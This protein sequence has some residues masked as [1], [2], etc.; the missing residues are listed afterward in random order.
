M[1][2]LFYVLSYA[3]IFL[4]MALLSLLMP[5]RTSRVISRRVSAVLQ[6]KRTSASRPEW[7]KEL[8]QRLLASIHWVR[9]HL[10][11]SESP[12]LVERFVRAGLRSSSY[13]EVYLA[14]RL[15]GP[16]VGIV[17]GSF[18]P[19]SKFFWMAV[20]GGVAYL[21]PDML[22][23]RAVKNRRERIRLSVPDAVDLLVICVDAGL[24]L[25]QAMLR[26]A[27]EL[28]VSH[29]DIRDEFFQINS[30][31]RAGKVRLEAWQSMAERLMVPE[32]DAFTNMLMQNE[33][34]GT[35]I[36][37]ALS[38]FGD[39]LRQKRRQRAEELAAKTTVKI[40]F[41]LVFFIFPS[42]FF[43]L[44]G[45]AAINIMRGMASGQ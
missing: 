33:R 27:Q 17:A 8:N 32:I 44:L 39:G 38:T 14:S 26:A 28:S 40:I 23:S 21:L 34:F 43:V 6:E 30:E 15:V 16:L 5:G 42:M 45:P 31:Q 41:P 12:K 20:F 9:S 10:G 25:D 35:P 4:A 22:L 11:M 37:R 19:S 29:P 18:I 13:R 3:S 24:G 1:Q 36:A 7:S 2:P